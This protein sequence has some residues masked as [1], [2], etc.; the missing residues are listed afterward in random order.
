MRHFLFKGKNKLIKTV[1]QEGQRIHMG[2]RERFK[3]GFF[4]AAAGFCC[5][6]SACKGNATPADDGGIVNGTTG[7]GADSITFA[8]DFLEETRLYVE[9]VYLSAGDVVQAGEKCIKF[10][11]DSIGSARA[12][13]DKAVR[14]GELACQSSVIYEGENKIMAK[15]AYD[16]ALL[17]AK[18]APQ[19]YEDTLALLETQSARA[20]KA[21]QEAQEEYEAYYS[22][23]QNNT[24]YEDFQ[25]E[26]LKNAYENA[27]DLYADRGK[28]WK[29]TPEELGSLSDSANGGR[30]NQDERQWMARTAALLKEEMTEARE[31]YEQAWQDY[32]REIEGAGLKL[33][34]LMNKSE[35]ARQALKDAQIEQQKGSLR[36][37]TSY[38]LALARGQLAE[39]NYKLC[40]MRFAE[41]LE[42]QKDAW[43]R[44]VENRELFEQLIGDGYLYTEKAG[45]VVTVQAEEGQP[46]AGQDLV[47]TYVSP[48]REQEE[49]AANWQGVAQSMYDADIYAE[50]GGAY[51]ECLKIAEIYTEEG[52]YIRKGDRVCRL[53][54]D[55]IEKVKKRLVRAQSEAASA[56]LEAQIK[57]HTGVL[58]AGLSRNEELSDKRLAQEVYD[59]TIAKMNSGMTAKI[60]E[61]E[62]LLEEIYQLQLSLTDERYL[63]QTAEITRAYDQA[64]KQAENARESYVTNQVKAA[65][66]LQAAR[67]AYEYFFSQLEKSNQQLADMAE[68]V[69]A[70]QDEIFQG[71]QLW[72][73]ELLAAQQERVRTWTEGETADDR[74]AGILGE[75]EKALDK[76]QADLDKA[77]QRL[78]SFN[79]FAGDGIVY[80]AGDGVVAK[81]GFGSG[82][83]LTST[84]KLLLFVPETA[85]ADAGE[86][87]VETGAIQLETAGQTVFF[88]LSAL[89]GKNPDLPVLQ[90]DKALAAPGQRVQK[91]MPLFR[92][93]PDSVEKVRRALQRE[94]DEAGKDYKALRARQ[95]EQQLQARQGADS[96][97]MNGKYAGVIYS[98][99]SGELQEKAD[100]AERAVADRQDQVNENLLELARTQQELVKAQEYLKKASADVAENYDKRYENPYYYTVY[101]NTRETA[102]DMAGQLERRVKKLTEENESLLYDV[103]GA[104]RAYHQELFDI[105]KEKL[106]LKKEYET[107]IYYSQKASEWY[108][109]QT[110][111]LD[112][113]VREAKERYESALRDIH[114]FNA[115]I[116]GDKVLC[117][118]NGMIADI[119]PATGKVMIMTESK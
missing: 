16:T 119:S 56:L 118:D 6:F 84:E 32:R 100:N 36:A 55:S 99:K 51:M 105:E 17:E 98:N 91:G 61:S 71:Q 59:N 101:E 52:Q 53:T 111:G 33:Q 103:D 109:I 25:I 77:T 89:S 11:D 8:I 95:K 23:V 115:Y 110:A 3:I 78:D 24:F 2:N 86:E 40:L 87:I 30:A 35:L 42:C 20:K 93:T 41:G 26:K 102:E 54:Q 43:D 31:E 4:L 66:T 62:R 46:L 73:K 18:Q 1:G 107:E 22:A 113:G 63:E 28:Y 114:Q 81:T 39:N 38:E 64:K 68:E 67:E 9:E 44:A 88:D 37:K 116:A 97:V 21:Y 75:Y 79:S 58:E 14:D 60:L 50:T 7:S 94:L 47:F 90:A 34:M 70:I 49:K 69:C 82:D 96:Y 57:Y 13:L 92:V 29:V 15:Y 19:V 45:T 108:D 48:D 83:W 80:A 74:Y 117:G 85:A 27:Y 10:T 104:L 106:A 76:A 72:E 65:G 12:E 112:T 5:F